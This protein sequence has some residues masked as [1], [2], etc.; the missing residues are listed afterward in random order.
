MRSG[1]APSP[2]NTNTK[3]LAQANPLPPPPA[4]V[5]ITL[6][7]PANEW[8][9][10]KYSQQQRYLVRETPAIHQAVTRPYVEQ[11]PPTQLGWV[12]AIID[13]RKEMDRLLYEVRRPPHAVIPLR[14]GSRPASA[15]RALARQ[16]RRRRRSPLHG[17]SLHPPPRLDARRLFVFV[18]SLRRTTTS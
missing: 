9:I 10:S 12:Q 13:R 15:V 4:Q 2:P 1:P 3:L 18:P 7:C 11:I 14:P 16:P 8:D 6:I 17:H 5:S